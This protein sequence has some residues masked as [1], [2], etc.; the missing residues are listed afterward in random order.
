MFG[1][2]THEKSTMQADAAYNKTGTQECCKN[3]PSGGELCERRG[4]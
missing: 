4:V 1:K 3:K 2:D